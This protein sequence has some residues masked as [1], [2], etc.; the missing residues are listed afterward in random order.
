MLLI[1]WTSQA[2]KY[3]GDLNL[4]LA[5][6]KKQLFLLL[7]SEAILFG[8]LLFL[9]YLSRSPDI[10]NSFSWQNMVFYFRG[11]LPIMALT[12]LD[13]QMF[14][15]LSNPTWECLIAALVIDYVVLFITTRLKK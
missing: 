11:V 6:S 12:S 15:F 9:Y 13:D 14:K 2:I 1:F 10:A 5:L 8:I 7:L 3:K 4:G